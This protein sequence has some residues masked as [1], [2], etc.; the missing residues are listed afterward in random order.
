[1]QVA[2]PKGDGWL[3][4]DDGVAAWMW[5]AGEVIS[6]LQKGVGEARILRVR[7]V[8]GLNIEAGLAAFSFKKPPLAGSCAQRP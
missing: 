4:T 8:F 6:K 1:L 5:L 7:S 3:D 2:Q